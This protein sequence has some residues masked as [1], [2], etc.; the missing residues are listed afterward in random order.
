MAG[1]ALGAVG[2]WLAPV[3]WANAGFLIGQTVGN[4]LFPG[5]HPDVRNEGPRLTDLNPQTSDYG[6]TLPVIYGTM[7][8]G[9]NVVWKKPLREVITTSTEK[10]G[11]K[12]GPSQSVTTVTYRYFADFFLALSDC[13]DGPVAGDSRIWVNGELVY[14]IRPGADADTVVASAEFAQFFRPLLGTA[15]QA[16]DPMIEADLGVG[17]TPAFRHTHGLVFEGLEVTKWGTY[18]QIKVEVVADG[19]AGQL[20]TYYDG[21]AT[22]ANQWAMTALVSDLGELWYTDTGYGAPGAQDRIAILNLADRS[23]SYILLPAPNNQLEASSYG[24]LLLMA[25]SRDRAY[26]NA[27]GAGLLTALEYSISTRQFI[28]KLSDV[29]PS[30]NFASS[31]F[32]LDEAR[33]RGLVFLRSSSSAVFAVVDLGSLAILNEQ[34]HGDPFLGE[35]ALPD[36]DGNFWFSHIGSL[37][38]KRMGVAGAIDSFPF[39]AD[40]CQNGIVARDPSRNCL[41]YWSEIGTGADFLKK[42]DMATG[43]VSRL[44]AVAY[45]ATEPSPPRGQL[46]YAPD[47]DRIIAV[48]PAGPSRV[49]V[50]DPIDGSI[51]ASYALNAPNAPLFGS[52][53]Y[54]AGVIWGGADSWEASEKGIGQFQLGALNESPP[55][56][57]AVITKI[58]AKVGLSPSDI[59]VTELTGDT[60]AGYALTR[61]GPARSALEPL[62]LAGGIDVVESGG[63]I[64][65]VKRGGA[66]A[67]V[68]EADD[69]GARNEGDEWRPPLQ[70][71][72]RLETE[73]PREVRVTS[74]DADRNYADSVDYARR[75]VGA[76]AEVQSIAL[77]MRLTSAQRRQIALRLLYGSWGAATG[78]EFDTTNRWLHLEP[79]DNVQVPGPDNT[80]YTARIE[81]KTEAR[82]RASFKA[83]TED[84]AVYTQFGSG[85]AAPVPTT[86]IRRTGNTM[87]RIM[88]IPLLRPEDDGDGLYIAACGA[89]AGWRGCEIW[90]S[91][92]GVSYSQAGLVMSAATPMGYATTALQDHT[93]GNV[94]DTHS[95]LTVVLIP[96]SGT[97]STI[98][99]QQFY[100]GEQG[101]LIGGEVVLFRDATLIAANTYTIK[102]FLR[103]RAGTA[104]ALAGHV[105]GEAFTLLS[106]ASLKRLAMAASDR[107]SVR[108][109]KAV[110]AGRTET[111]TSPVSLT[112]NAIGKKPL[113]PIDLFAGKQINGDWVLTWEVISR[114]AEGWNPSVDT[115]ADGTVYDIEIWDSSFATLKRTISSIDAKTHTYTGA[116]QTTDF[117]SG[118]TTL[119]WRLHPTSADFGRGDYAQRTS[120]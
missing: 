30:Y 115:P 101:A 23:Y 51:E 118:Q 36:E 92:D 88:D 73:L 104:F 9:G 49:Y 31:M 90:R 109:F 5:K 116:E 63:I 22:T 28:R 25:P 52:L 119:Y 32:G 100:D 29:F 43:I 34:A 85:A 19:S 76:S 7:A 56:Y 91:N 38:F 79:T 40:G 10:Q 83:A 24:R 15:T 95:E 69:L 33:G 3:G 102:T 80:L 42:L 8:V 89:F 21:T 47:I 48:K 12:G 37:A 106:P 117:G 78:L 62:L 71:T 44:N 105:A 58:C 75:Q 26:V 14:D 66:V 20:E 50:L 81:G 16:V 68:I 98:T 67:A 61:V 93:G 64:K 4:L 110:T 97:L 18:P 46:I 13:S 27:T 114:L 57:A 35:Q 107:G 120:T 65:F 94:I 54:A 53:A 111:A 59:D 41:Y 87:M 74:A 113:T 6:R 2:A 70:V 108:H 99:E 77:P 72:G 17:N 1:L 86:S 11:G 82:S 103:A 39:G 45:S 96:N 112:Y 84:I 60:V 55:T